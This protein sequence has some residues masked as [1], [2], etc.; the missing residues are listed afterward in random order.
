MF[1]SAFR[2]SE[3]PSVV[4]PEAAAQIE[5]F[6]RL[7]SMKG[8]STVA[9]FRSWLNVS[10]VS[11]LDSSFH[12]TRLIDKASPLLKRG[13]AERTQFDNA[14]LVLKKKDSKGKTEYL[15]YELENVLV[16]SYSAK[17]S[18]F[19]GQTAGKQ[20]TFA[21]TFQKIKFSNDLKFGQGKSLAKADAFSK[22]RFFMQ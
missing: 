10:K 8:S 12:F 22:M 21:L 15:K 2:I 5:V 6:M 18:G 13:S 3:N 1:A 7:D 16:S 19:G 17:S 9:E 20:E 14:T 4:V 11:V